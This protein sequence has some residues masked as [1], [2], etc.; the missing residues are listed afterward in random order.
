MIFFRFQEDPF[1][2]RQSSVFDSN[3]LA[4]GRVLPGFSGQTEVQDPMDRGDLGFIHRNRCSAEPDDVHDAGRG[5]DGDT[6]LR[7]VQAAKYVARK[8]RE[9]DFGDALGPLPSGLV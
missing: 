2:S 9:F 7:E 6:A 5:D 4:R 3:S 8:E 1:H